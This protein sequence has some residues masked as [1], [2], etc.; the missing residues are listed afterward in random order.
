M[1]SPRAALW[2]RRA[3]CRALVAG[4]AG[5]LLGPA[6]AAAPAA[7]ARRITLHNTH[8]L[9]SLSVEYRD[10]AGY[11][12]DALAAL[13]R[14]L[15]DHRSG[16]VHPMDPALMDLLCA[17]AERVGREPEFEVISG[18]RSPASNALLHARSRGVAA[19]SLH[20]AGRA[21]DLRLAG[22]DLARLRDTA[23]ALARGG[24]GYYPRSAFVHLDTGRV[25]SWS[26]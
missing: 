17:A 13:D 12:A 6:A 4:T 19:G 18:Y 7:G 25:R 10:A 23:L 11:R 3:A 2:S 15:R 14:V 21:I 1:P 24:V 5:A 8:T 26:G 9:E 16:A 20:M 22:C